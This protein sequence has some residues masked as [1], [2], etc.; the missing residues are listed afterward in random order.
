MKKKELITDERMS[1]LSGKISM[2]FLSLTQLG[3]LG[4]ILYQ[5]YVLEL[6][7]QHYN[8]L[9]VLL[10]F[11]VFGYFATKL[12]FGAILPVVK[13][14]TMIIIYLAFV[15]FLTIVLS[16]IYGLPT[17]DN[18]KNTILPVLLGPAI[19]IA[20]YMLFAFLGRRRVEKEIKE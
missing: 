1:N 6:P 9:R 14:K 11:S 12:Y 18:W 3:L 15:T 13:F 10:A 7:E 19:I 2:I 8:D 4:L 17:L 5:R 20:L 16:I